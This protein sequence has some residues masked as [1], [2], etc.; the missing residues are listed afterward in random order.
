MSA[1]HFQLH[2]V[3][4]RPVGE[5][6]IDSAG[7]DVIERYT[8][9]LVEKVGRARPLRRSPGLMAGTRR[10]CRWRLRHER[11]GSFRCCRP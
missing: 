4:A 7:A 6:L 11:A 2:R 9:E 1:Q 3:D 8:L 10:R 5:L